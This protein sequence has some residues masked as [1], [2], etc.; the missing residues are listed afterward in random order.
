MAK[1]WTGFQSCFCHRLPVKPW[2][3]H[4]ISLGLAVLGCTMGIMPCYP[5]SQPVVMGRGAMRVQGECLTHNEVH[6]QSHPSTC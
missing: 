4:F 5:A 6:V 3:S 2:A 1:A